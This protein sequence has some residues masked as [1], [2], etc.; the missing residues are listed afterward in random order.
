MSELDEAFAE[1]TK[2]PEKT[3][4]CWACRKAPATVES[5]DGWWCEPCYFKW[6]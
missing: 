4:E 2:Q 1:L 3:D 6:Q 5:F